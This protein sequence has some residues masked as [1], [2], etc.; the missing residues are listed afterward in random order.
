MQVVNGVVLVM[1]AYEMLSKGE[2]DWENGFDLAMGALNVLTFSRNDN[3]LT[4][5]GDTALSFTGLGTVYA[6]VT[7][8]C[9]A[10]SL[11]GNAGKAA[12]HLTN[13]ITGICYKYNP[14][15]EET[16]P[17]TLTKSM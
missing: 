6:G 2:L 1:A 4:S 12:L 17:E 16:A 15:Q 3:A 11:V 5:L 8:G 14:Q 13:A 9:T 7:S 10:S